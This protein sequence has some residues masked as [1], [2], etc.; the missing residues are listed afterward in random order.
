MYR[1]ADILD[2][3]ANVPLNKQNFEGDKITFKMPYDKH[4]VYTHDHSIY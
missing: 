4:N 3:S 1:N 2:N